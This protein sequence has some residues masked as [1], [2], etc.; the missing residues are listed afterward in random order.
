MGEALQQM[1]SEGL[2]L[3]A[4][5]SP[6][7]GISLWLL[8]AQNE[9]LQ[10]RIEAKAWLLLRAGQAYTEAELYSDAGQSLRS[11]LDLADAPHIQVTILEAQG[12]LYLQ[13]GQIEAA[14][15]TYNT[16]LSFRESN[17]EDSLALANNMSR[18]GEVHWLLEENDTAEEYE[19]SAIALRARLAP[20]T[21]L[22]HD[23]K[24]LGREAQQSGKLDLA[25]DNYNKALQLSDQGYG[26]AFD[27]AEISEVLSYIHRQQGNLEQSESLLERALAVREENHPQ[28][29]ETAR[30]LTQ[31]GNIAY[32]AN[33]KEQTEDY[34]DRALLIYE[35][36]SQRDPGFAQLLQNLG[37]LALEEKET[38]IAESHFLRALEIEVHHSRNSLQHGRILASLGDAKAQ[39][40]LPGEAI[41]HYKD[42]LT[43]LHLHLHEE[44]E[45]ASLLDRL[46]QAHLARGDLD[47]AEGFLLQ[48]RAIVERLKPDSEDLAHLMHHLGHVAHQRAELR[49]AERRF[50]EAL[51]IFEIEHPE[52]S[53]SAAIYQHLASIANQQ[54]R[55]R[56]AQYLAERAWSIE[57]T[58]DPTGKTALESLLSLGHATDSLGDFESAEFYQAKARAIQES[59]IPDS[60][61]L[62]NNLDMLGRAAMC[63]NEDS[64]AFDYWHRA[65]EIKQTL[66]PRSYAVAESLNNI[67]TAA[68]NVND[69]ATAE[70]NLKAALK[71]LTEEAPNSELLGIALTNFGGVAL[72]KGD[73]DLAEEHW[74][75]AHRHL[76]R[77][78]PDSTSNARALRHLGLVAS[79]QGDLARAASYYHRAF[80]IGRLADPA[81]NFGL[82]SSLSG[83]GSV[84][85]TLGEL[86]LAESYFLDALCILMGSGVDDI[87]MAD[88]FLLLAE[89]FRR[90][91]RP[92]DAIEY[93][94][95]A[96]EIYET[97]LH[98][99]TRKASKFESLGTLAKSNGDFD[100]ARDY[101][102]RAEELLMT[103][104]PNSK[105]AAH[106]L[107]SQGSLER[108]SGNLE[109]AKEKL[110]RSIEVQ[111]DNTPTSF[112]T[113]MALDELGLVAEAENNIE[114]AIAYYERSLA[115]RQRLAPK[116][117]ATA[118]SLHR[119]ANVLSKS[120]A[121]EIAADTLLD[122]LR[123]LES[124]FDRIGTSPATSGNY[125]DQYK[126][127]Y[128]DAVGFLAKNGR[129]DDSL[130]QLERFRGKNFLS[131][132]A[133]KDLTFSIDIGA[134]DDLERRRLAT[135]YDLLQLR[136]ASFDPNSE[137]AATLRGQLRL[138]QEKQTQLFAKIR[139]TSPGVADLRDPRPLD[140]SGIQQA[141]DPGTVMLSYNVRASETDLF[142]I[143]PDSEPMSFVLPID[144]DALWSL[145]EGYRELLSQPEASYSS[146]VMQT[147]VSRGQELYRTLLG[148][149]NDELADSTRILFVPDG[150]L[151]LLPWGALVI[152]AGDHS[153]SSNRD[154]QYLVEW[155]PV[156]TALSAT[157]YETLKRG[158][159][160][161][162]VVDTM[163]PS[164][165][166]MA[167]GDPDYPTGI[168]SDRGSESLRASAQRGIFDWSQL[169]DS[170]REIQRIAAVFPSQE[171]RIYLGP[172]ATEGVIKAITRSPQILHIASH[173]YLDDRFPMN[174]AL[175]LTI[176]QQLTQG[177]DNGLLQ[178]W[179]II[180]RVRL[181]ADLVVLSGCSTALGQERAGEGLLG[182]TRAF[183]FAGARSV[184]ASLWTVDDQ[185]TAELMILF[186]RHLRE[187]MSK[188][189]ALRSAQ[190]ALIRGPLRLQN[191]EGHVIE[192]DFTA[193]FHWAAFQ[194]YGDWQ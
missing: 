145:I 105:Q 3:I 55:F 33:R 148:P 113:A 44:L 128:R 173:A 189:E 22:I 81:S 157:V 192:K 137:E 140:L 178:V 176:P 179:E 94:E 160:R 111:S 143:R 125:V 117:A 12:E 37:Q 142:L 99:Q 119:L 144:E 49:L 159:Q 72:N 26:N 106:L 17:W 132:L 39:M 188:D 9:E 41:D 138:V 183:Q 67:A 184:L 14:R 95:S 96:Q 153:R 146:D 78:A 65:L 87:R 1:Y 61:E 130:R 171:T 85:T 69:S 101:F 88:V 48:S 193:P 58:R 98:G 89:N 11:A 158:R 53:I 7:A 165:Q 118:L 154:W 80:A 112:L 90:R 169:P 194:V 56:A 68:M 40:A 121:K 135:A 104:A 31:L 42:A 47:T 190:R 172:E 27:L 60:C 116:A 6:Q 32:N 25:R 152:A 181:D 124:Q 71:I 102:L 15:L 166:L 187:G 91:G 76:E 46:G 73:V 122:A 155:K 70:H 75:L 120:G 151:H 21:R 50:S 86:A 147:L 83:L 66:A 51:K 162:R 156:H 175:V 8:A 97:Q 114:S 164:L 29:P 103:H 174:S 168:S 127:I 2:E 62:A 170:R 141:L 10:H 163:V 18:L 38:G 16:A 79:V 149:I 123:T 134:E 5:D 186:Y 180:E 57:E 129:L 150:P 110:L 115:L 136:L 54:G 126:D 52:C 108:S 36:R 133:E 109:S 92:D 45:I 28:D 182:L 93:V 4:S 167:F 30:T 185:S 64:A 84:A 63:R 19:S 23:L 100:R 13:Q 35:N 161:S 82:A 131:M 59:F 24:N 177:Q 34:Y 43:I 20:P 139:K 191:E 107:L 77:V 74:R